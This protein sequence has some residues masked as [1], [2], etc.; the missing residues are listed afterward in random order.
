MKQTNKT[1]FTITHF[2]SPVILQSPKT[3]ILT[4]YGR[5]GEWWKMEQHLS[6]YRLS[7]DEKKNVHEILIR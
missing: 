6:I 3:A 1:R 4:M 5:N 7:L 2:S